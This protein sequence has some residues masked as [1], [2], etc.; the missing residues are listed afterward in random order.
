M[1][2]EIKDG[3]AQD[4]YECSKFKT[5]VKGVKKN[6]RIVLHTIVLPDL[7]LSTFQKL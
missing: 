5:L 4:I 2:I 1:V 3:I 7:W 6:E